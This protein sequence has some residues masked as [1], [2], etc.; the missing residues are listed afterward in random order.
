MKFNRKSAAALFLA[1][2]FSASGVYAGQSYSPYNGYAVRSVQVSSDRIKPEILKNRF[3]LKEGESFDAE[4]YED[5]QNELHDLRIAKKLSFDL[6]PYEDKKVDIAIKAEDGYYIFPLV[7]ATGGKKSAAGASLAAGN[8]FKRGESI[9]LFGGSGKDGS[10][11]SLMLKDGD[12]IYQASLVNMNFEQRFYGGSR[13]SNDGIFSTTD[14]E[15]DFKNPIN[16][17]Y[18]KTDSFSFLYARQEGALT[19]FVSPEYK[20]IRYSHDMKSG[21]YSAVSFGLNYRRNIRS[22][23]NMGA[24][25]GYGLT[26]KEQSLKNLP[27]PIVGYS[28]QAAYKNGGDWTGADFDISKIS[29]EA[30][31]VI[32]FK[33]RHILNVYLK[34]EDSFSSPFAE[35]V[36]AEDLMGGQGRYS[37]TLY[38]ER[39]AG[40][41]ISFAYYLARNNT[42]LLALQPF[43]ELA[44]VRSDKY[45]AL[46]GAGATLSYK[47]WRFPFPL[48]L[49]YT[50]NLSD[51]SNQISFVFG[52]KF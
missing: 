6:T 31:S 10:T 32:E 4:R 24:L 33:T 40:T 1:G 51:G 11:A 23:A 34:A 36:R 50:Q 29:A 7:F 41:G 45:R 20:Y 35:Q 12:N 17:I 46:S 42:G 25:F 2:L 15:E 16:R 8:L 38:G 49:N 14:D 30:R 27:A 21:N 9:M 13:I 52:G 22:G 43:Y 48:G 37:R 39:G 5:A 44:Y 18:T 47:F 28:L 19:G 26:D 3:P